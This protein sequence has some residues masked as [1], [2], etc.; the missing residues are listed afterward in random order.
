MA[1]SQQHEPFELGPRSLCVWEG[2]IQVGD[3]GR[4]IATFEMRS[5]TLEQ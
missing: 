1:S 3:G 4:E 5:A 2:R